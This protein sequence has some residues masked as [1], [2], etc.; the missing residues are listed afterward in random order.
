MHLRIQV[1]D[2]TVLIRVCAA[3]EYE[4][5]LIF[6]CSFQHFP[7]ILQPLSQE[8][9]LVIPC[10]RYPYHKLVAVR[11]HRLFK[12]V[13]LLGFFEC[14]HLVSNGD[15]AIQGVLDIGVCR[16]GLYVKRPVRKL[17][18]NGVFVVIVYHFYESTPFLAQLQAVYV[19]I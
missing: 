7:A 19:V 14:M 8:Q 10:G 17:A 6:H 9:L 13:V 5:L 12:Q 1:V 2:F 11:L 3:H 18:P 4:I 16:Q 15:V